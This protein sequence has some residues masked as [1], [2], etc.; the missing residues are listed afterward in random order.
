MLTA[1]SSPH[2]LTPTPPKGWG[3]THSSLLSLVATPPHFNIYVYYAHTQ[4][5]TAW[6]CSEGKAMTPSRW[7][8]WI[9]PPALMQVGQAGRGWVMPG[10]DGLVGA[11]FLIYDER[12]TECCE[13]KLR[14]WNQAAWATC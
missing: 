10:G 13:L 11:E 14:H 9:E 7:A 12:D 6:G 5:V 1:D 2:P 8:A 3:E 4:P